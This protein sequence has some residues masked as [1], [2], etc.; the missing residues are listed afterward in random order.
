MSTRVN[1]LADGCVLNICLANASLTTQTKLADQ[2][3]VA[4]QILALQVVQQLTT[5]VYHT[6]Q[7]TTRVVILVVSFEVTLQLIDL[8]SQQSNLYFRGTGIALSTGVFGNNF[9]FLFST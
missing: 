6:D 8:R 4:I 3:S 7:T 9:C 1:P 2:C 5:L